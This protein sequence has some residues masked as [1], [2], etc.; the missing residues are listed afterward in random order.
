[1]ANGH[2]LATGEMPTDTTVRY[3]LAFLGMAQ[4]ETKG[5]KS[6][7]KRGR[8]CGGAGTLPHSWWARRRAVWEIL[9]TPNGESYT[10]PSE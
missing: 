3:H 6:D 7:H 2:S 5:D 10:R 8:E 4:K 1:M 9:K